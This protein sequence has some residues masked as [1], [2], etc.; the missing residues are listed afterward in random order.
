ML[1]IHKVIRLELIFQQD[2]TL[3]N[4]KKKILKRLKSNCQPSQGDDIGGQMPTSLKT[5]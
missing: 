1:G 5:E 4:E 2:S 3:I